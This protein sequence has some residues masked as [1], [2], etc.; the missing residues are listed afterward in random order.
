LDLPKSH[1]ENV[2]IQQPALESVG[3]KQRDGLLLRLLRK[4]ARL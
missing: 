3:A 4:V 2:D 1:A